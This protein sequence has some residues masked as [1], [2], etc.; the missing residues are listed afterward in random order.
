LEARR[1]INFLPSSNRETVPVRPVSDPA[2]R[3]DFSLNTLVPENA[4][5][6]YDMKELLLRIVDEADFFEIQPDYAKNLIVGFGRMEGRTVGFVAN[7]P[8]NLAGCL[9]IAAS[10]KGARFIR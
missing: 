10:R 5:K 4:N 2:D 1:L 7:Q 3:L 6:P 9:D 8:M